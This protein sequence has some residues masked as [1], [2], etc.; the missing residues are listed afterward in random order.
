MHSLR[1]GAATRDFLRGKAIEDILHRGRW[2][3]VKAARNYVQASPAMLLAMEA[4]RSV[5]RLGA[6]WAASLQHSF[7]L[8]QRL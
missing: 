3:S 4:P 6:Q 1:H 2:V 5:S 7:A 8:A